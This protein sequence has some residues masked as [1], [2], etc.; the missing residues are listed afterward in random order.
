MEVWVRF[1]AAHLLRRCRRRKVCSSE[2]LETVTHS[3]L[4][5]SLRTFASI[6]LVL[7]ANKAKPLSART[8]VKAR[9]SCTA[10]IIPA[11]AEGRSAVYSPRVL[12]R[13]I[14]I[15]LNMCSLLSVSQSLLEIRR[16]CPP[17]PASAL[18]ACLN[19]LTASTVTSARPPQRLFGAGLLASRLTAAVVDGELLQLHV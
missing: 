6:R 15:K 10:A 9:S 8:K 2:A 14:I 12:E 4:L 7:R 18:L 11:S 13:R 19:R 3:Y 5:L 1:M 16:I 17:P